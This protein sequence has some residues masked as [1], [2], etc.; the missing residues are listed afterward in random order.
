MKTKNDI[1]VK[2]WLELQKLLFENSWD[3]NILRHRSPYAF[4]G[5]SDKDYELRTSL[6]RLGGK[7]EDMERHLLRNF[8]KYSPKGTLDGDLIW[9]WLAVA[10]HHGLPTRLLDW[11]YSPYIALH[12]VTDDLGKYEK[13]GVI[14]CM[15][16][17]K[18]N[19]LLPGPL[20][21]ILKQESSLVFTGEMLEGVCKSISDLEKL[22]SSADEFVVFLEPPSFDERI[23]NQY[24]LFSFMSSARS[25]LNEW[26]EDH[27]GLFFRIII[28][29][30]LKWEIRDKLD[31]VNI[32][33]RVL[34]PGLDGLSAWLRRYYRPPR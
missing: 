7:Y 12:F 29:A 13:D 21:N 22:K 19:E 5:L 18:S 3:E 4:R 34:F 31:E 16:Y 14:W 33:E 6:M 20:R 27:P 30:K 26:L 24:A 17:M 28:P 15:D 32:T 25:V 10:Q 8:R 9:D 2:N 23:I 11:T 1:T